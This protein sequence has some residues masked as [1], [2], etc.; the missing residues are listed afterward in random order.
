MRLAQ[1]VLSVRPLVKA[2]PFPVRVAPVLN[3]NAAIRPSDRIAEGYVGLAELL[4]RVATHLG[5]L[6]L[7]LG[8]DETDAD[9]FERIISNRLGLKEYYEHVC[10]VPIESLPE[11]DQLVDDVM[12][13]AFDQ[14]CVCNDVR[15]FDGASLKAYAMGERHKKAVVVVSACCMPAK[16]CEPWMRF[17][18]NEYFAITW[19]NRGLFGEAKEFD[20]L[21]YNVGAQA[22]DLFAVM[23]HFGVRNAHLMG[24]C[25][26]TVIALEAA[27]ARPARASSLSLW[28]GD[29]DLGPDCPKT[30]HQHN[31]K[32]LLAMAAENRESA[33]LIRAILCHSIPANLQSDLAHLVLYPYANEELLFRY[34]RLNGSIMDTNVSHVLDKIS[35]PTL[36]VTSEDDNT[37][38]PAGSKRVAAGIAGATLRVEPHG[39][40]LSLFNADPTL[41]GIAAHFISE[42]AY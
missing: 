16:L 38:H 8:T 37:A 23:D 27:A 39:D 3:G 28:H 35:Q 36:V 19:E 15:S 6:Q 18:A 20:Q 21:A 7:V 26:G 40:H 31:L 12:K 9:V 5:T 33:T 22:E 10:A 24:L 29:Y 1:A 25:G 11:V 4:C 14:A 2:L 30:Y 41:T 17:L 32:A 34:S 13:D 42:E